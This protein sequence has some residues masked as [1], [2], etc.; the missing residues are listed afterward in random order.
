MPLKV[1]TNQFQMAPNMASLPHEPIMEMGREREQGTFQRDPLSGMSTFLDNHLN[2][3]LGDI[4]LFWMLGP[5]LREL[6]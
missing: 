5:K 3:L 1:N 6:L 4:F 2:N